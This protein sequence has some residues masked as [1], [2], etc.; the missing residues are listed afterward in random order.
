MFLVR[1]RWAR[2]LILF[3]LTAIIIITIIY[4]NEPILRMLLVVF[5]LFTLYNLV[6]ETWVAL[7]FISPGK[8]KDN[9]INSLW[10]S[11][12]HELDTEIHSVSYFD[13]EVRP[14]AIIVHGWRSR[15]SSMQG[16]ANHYIKLGFHVIIFE[17]PGHGKSQPVSKWTAGHASTTF[18]DFFKQLESNFD[19]DLVNGIYLH[20]HSMGG[21]VL[22][23]FD[24]AFNSVNSA[25]RGYVLE[26]P[27][28]C[29]S[30]IFKES[31]DSLKIPKFAVSIFWR[32]L[33]SHFNQINPRIPDVTELSEVDTPIWGI[34]NNNC[35]VIQAEHDNRLGLEHYHNFVNH[36]KHI[37]GHIFEHHLISDLTHAGARVNTN[38]DE[39]IRLWL[40]KVSTY[41]DSE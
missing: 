41:S 16:R 7:A 31:V 32:R 21:F 22:L 28:T 14:L 30:L 34:I 8:R 13:N 23:R 24:R 26:S 20:G 38:R 9:K 27:M 19:M 3:L 12:F 35:L 37:T 25:I 6:V 40:E 4:V 36:Q 11:K 18:M 17:L 2:P 29:Y 10:T 15:A 39:K 1:Y 33:S 5:W